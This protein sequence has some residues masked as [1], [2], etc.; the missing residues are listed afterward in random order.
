MLRHT[1]SGI[2]IDISL[3]MLPFEI[4]AV[5][6]SRLHKIASMSIRLPTPED[7][8]ILKS[9][10]HRP[11]DML[12]IE[13]IVHV[14]EQLDVARISY[15]VKQFAALLEAPELWDDVDKLLRGKP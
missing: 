2:N 14:S 6:R 7:L 8:I 3:G 13:A 1:K 5:E 9:V 12:D 4:E 10:A 15:W 11:K